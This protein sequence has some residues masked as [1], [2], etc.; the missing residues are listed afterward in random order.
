MSCAVLIAAQPLAVD[1]VGTRQVHGHAGAFQTLDGLPVEGVGLLPVTEQRSGASLHAERPISA[2]GPGPLG[3]A[4]DGSGG[5]VGPGA[6]GGRL[7][8]LDQRPGHEPQVVVLARRDGGGQSSLVLAETVVEEGPGVLAPRQCSA[9]A[10]VDRVGDAELDEARHLGPLAPPCC[11][12][13]LR[14][15]ERRATDRSVERACFLDQSRGGG[16][17]A[18]V[19]VRA[20][21]IGERDGEDGEGAGLAGDPYLTDGDLLPGLVVPQLRCDAT[22]QP[23]PADVLLLL[24]NLQ[25]APQGMNPR[26]I[27]FGDTAG[28]AVQEQ[29]DRPRRFRPRGR[30]QSSLGHLHHT[31]VTAEPTGEDGGSERIEMRLTRQLGVERFEPLGRLEQQR[32]RIVPSPASERDLGVQPDRPRPVELIERAQLRRGEQGGCVVR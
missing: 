27:A 6:A 16:E 22:G 1:Q 17:L 15:H 3:E 5:D 24:D 32:W 29:I 7:D 28:H 18:R 8:Q 31:G 10:P 26:D 4:V 13:D 30:G 25:G 21:A 12:E 14:V 20:R 19:Q 23:E 11:Q 9:L 2:G